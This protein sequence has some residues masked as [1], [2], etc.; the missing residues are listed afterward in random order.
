M[1]NTPGQAETFKAE[2]N[3]GKARQEVT[4]LQGQKK[5]KLLNNYSG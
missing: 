3:T 4:Q 2:K 1:D 5:K